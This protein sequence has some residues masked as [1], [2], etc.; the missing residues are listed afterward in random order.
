MLFEYGKWY[1][2]LSVWYRFVDGLLC[3]L[4]FL[5]LFMI[6]ISWIT[7][8]R[9]FLCKDRVYNYMYS[10]EFLVAYDKLIES[11]AVRK[12]G[13]HVIKDVNCLEE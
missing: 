3:I 4:M 2:L 5:N 6:F 11:R 9:V 12:T 8:R 10:L 13:R 1:V 7:R